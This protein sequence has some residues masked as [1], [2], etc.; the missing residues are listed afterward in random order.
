MAR[1]VLDLAAVDADAGAGLPARTRAFARLAAADPRL[2]DRLVAAHLAARLPAQLPAPAGD[3][4]GQ[5]WWEQALALVPRLLAAEPAPKPARL[6]A[7]VFGACP[8]E[9][10]AQLETQVR[11]AL[12]TPPQAALI[13]EVLPSGADRVDGLAEPLASWL[14][15]WDWSP[16]LPAGVLAGWEPVL[17]AARRLKPASPSDPRTAPD[18]EPVKASTALAVEDLEQIAAARGVPQTGA[19]KTTT[20]GSQSHMGQATPAGRDSP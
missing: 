9:H 4:D 20:R 2:H 15:V 12:G 17:D 7:L 11:T 3:L 5:Q 14:R 16:V 8:P 18:L 6:V 13:E 19:Q 1:T 10:A